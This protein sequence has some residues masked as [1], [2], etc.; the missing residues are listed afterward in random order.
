[1]KGKKILAH[2]EK[3]VHENRALNGGKGIHTSL[4]QKLFSFFEVTTSSV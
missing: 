3:K 2:S 1:M 4:E